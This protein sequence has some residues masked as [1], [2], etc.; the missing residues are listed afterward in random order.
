MAKA[1]TRSRGLCA[2]GLPL[3]FLKP[4]AKSKRIWFF[5]TPI[6]LCFLLI[7]ISAIGAW[8]RLDAYSASNVPSS[9]LGLRRPQGPGYRTE[10]ASR[11]ELAQKVEFRQDVQG[12]ANK[13]ARTSKL[14]VAALLAGGMTPD[15]ICQDYPSLTPEAV[16]TGEG[17]RVS[18]P[19]G[20]P[21]LSVEDSKACS[22]G[23]RP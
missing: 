13:K 2:G 4:R 7:H 15:Q 9:R 10:R 8:A 21:S 18:P 1:A 23:R 6:L 16:A 14:R 11:P 19:E 3:A 20:R 5:K 17:L 12:R 22:Q